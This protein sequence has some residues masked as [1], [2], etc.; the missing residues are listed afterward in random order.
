M[1]AV[2]LTVALVLTSLVAKGQTFNNPR[3]VSS[4]A[5]AGNLEWVTREAS[6]S[7]MMMFGSKEDIRLYT[8]ELKEFFNLDDVPVVKNCMTF[9]FFGPNGV[10]MEM[11]VSEK[12]NNGVI[13]VK[14]FK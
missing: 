7:V 13:M 12:E 9:Y 8:T 10:A 2:V 3:V 5:E 14:K 4:I 6:P 1:K 11:V